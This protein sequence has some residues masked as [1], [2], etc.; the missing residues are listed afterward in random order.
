MAKKTNYSHKKKRRTHK[1]KNG[2]D[3]LVAEEHFGSSQ[4][5]TPDLSQSPQIPDLQFGEQ[6]DVQEDAVY[7]DDHHNYSD[8]QE[9]VFPQNYDDHHDHP[10]Q[11]ENEIPVEDNRQN[12]VQAGPDPRFSNDAGRVIINSV[13][14]E[15]ENVGSELR[16]VS[17]PGMMP[18]AMKRPRTERK[19]RRQRNQFQKPNS[20]FISAFA[21]EGPEQN[22]FRCKI[23]YNALNGTLAENGDELFKMSTD[24]E[25]KKKKNCIEQNS[26]KAAI[27]LGTFK[28][29]YDELIVPANRNEVCSYLARLWN[30]RI[31]FQKQ[32]FFENRM[33]QSENI[34]ADDFFSALENDLQGYSK[35]R[36]K[37]S[38]SSTSKDNSFENIFI[39]N[40]KSTVEDNEDIDWSFLPPYIDIDDVIHHFDECTQTD[41]TGVL[42]DS[43]F[44]VRHISNFIAKNLIFKKAVVTDL[45]SE[46]ETAPPRMVIDE[47]SL[48]AYLTSVKVMKE[49]A[50]EY[51]ATMREEKSSL[52]FNNLGLLRPMIPNID[53]MKTVGLL[54]QNTFLKAKSE[55]SK[56]A[57]HQF[58]G[59]DTN[60][61]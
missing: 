33:N 55:S 10:P 23:C 59:G 19:M 54:K 16:L 57:K 36:S 32:Q 17:V 31:D 25:Y 22:D 26:E 52:L 56:G 6:E 29:K 58:R 3:L 1:E 53:N 20:S 14:E 27:F 61:I 45:E 9:P 38:S 4:N 43:L 35:T 13:V 46:T 51:R 48:F 18:S 41:I 37:S 21:P 34:T 12:P 42:R 30:N 39:K 40:E 60:G 15:E 50:S 5:S 8:T 24:P 7:D 44:Q 28:M 49:V 2:G 11:T 47:K